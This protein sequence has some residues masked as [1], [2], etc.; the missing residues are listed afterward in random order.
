MPCSFLFSFPCWWQSQSNSS[1]FEFKDRLSDAIITM[2]TRMK[3]WFWCCCDLEQVQNTILCIRICGH[4]TQD[5]QAPPSQ[6]N[7]HHVVENCWKY[8]K[9][10]IRWELFSYSGCLGSWEW[11]DQERKSQGIISMEWQICY[12]DYHHQE[13]HHDA[14]Q[15]EGVGGE[16]EVL[17]VV[18]GKYPRSGWKWP[19]VIKVNCRGKI[20]GWNFENLNL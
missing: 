16:G 3:C 18:S 19:S 13:E 17:K 7:I 11:V 6:E 20:I 1:N 14:E 9:F 10:S 12:I 8:F 2:V 4:S 15:D 5:L